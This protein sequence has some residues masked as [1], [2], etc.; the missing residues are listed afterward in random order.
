M[1]ITIDYINFIPGCLKCLVTIL[2]IAL[3][4]IPHVPIMANAVNAL[5]IT[6]EAGKRRDACFPN[7]VKELMTGQLR[8]S[9]EIIK[10]IVKRDTGKML[11]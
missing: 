4:H 6:A 9:T 7:P 11:P 10:R 2:L 3:V 8:I 1:F 5:H